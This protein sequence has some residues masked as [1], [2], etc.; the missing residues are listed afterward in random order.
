[1]LQYQGA[2]FPF[3][4]FEGVLL[5]DTETLRNLEQNQVVVEGECGERVV[6]GLWVVV[7]EGGWIVVFFRVVRMLVWKEGTM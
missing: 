4:S 6:D 3:Y 2:H 7:V 1:M 5:W